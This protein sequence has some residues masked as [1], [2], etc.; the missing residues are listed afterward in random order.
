MGRKLPLNTARPRCGCPHSSCERLTRHERAP[1]CGGAA[2]P[3]SL[4]A[5]PGMDVDKDDA[6]AKPGALEALLLAPVAV[7][8]ASPAAVQELEDRL[9]RRGAALRAVLEGLPDAVVA[10]G[11]DGRILFANDQAETLFGYARDELLG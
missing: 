5:D 6:G 8:R 2:D 1:C 7:D 4:I 3:H 9:R 11:R 10:A